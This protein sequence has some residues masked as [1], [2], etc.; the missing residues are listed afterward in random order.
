MK[1]ENSLVQ[2]VNHLNCKTSQRVQ[3]HDWEIPYLLPFHVHTFEL[4]NGQHLF[5]FFC[6]FFKTFVFGLSHAFHRIHTHNHNTWIALPEV[7]VGMRSL[8]CDS[9]TIGTQTHITEVLCW[10]RLF[11]VCT[12]IR[13]VF[14]KSSCCIIFVNWEWSFYAK[15]KAPLN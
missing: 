14:L 13:F 15:T 11:S 1:K 3:L 5:L 2:V 9:F 10:P 8:N 7:F 12:S 4:A 6:L